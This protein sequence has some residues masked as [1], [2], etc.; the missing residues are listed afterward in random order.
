MGV[1][2][3]DMPSAMYKS[4]ESIAEVDREV[5]A[6]AERIP[7][8]RVPHRRHDS[9]DLLRRLA[10]A[11]NTPSPARPQATP[12]ELLDEVETLQGNVDGLRRLSDALG[13]FNESFASWLY[14][15]NMNALTTDWIQA[16]NDASF[17]VLNASHHVYGTTNLYEL[18]FWVDLSVSG[19][20]AC[21]P[22]II[23]GFSLNTFWFFFLIAIERVGP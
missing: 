21:S 5:V 13:T 19:N 6:T 8:K 16:P 1:G 10:R 18:Y 17:K 14:V 15:M 23:F 7:P 12:P 4:T 3:E 9:Q 22:L 2:K 11:S 20:G